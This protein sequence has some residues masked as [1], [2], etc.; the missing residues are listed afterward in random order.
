MKKKNVRP[1]ELADPKVYMVNEGD[2]DDDFDLS[3]LPKEG[4][5]NEA[6]DGAAADDTGKEGDQGGSGGGS[7]GDGA[8]ESG[9]GE[10]GSGKKPDGDSGDGEGGKAKEGDD[11]GSGDGGEGEGAAG[12]ESGD[13][14]GKE[15]DGS[16][17]GSGEGEGG[18]AEGKAGD[19]KGGEGE[20]GE[21]FFGDINAA[22]E[23]ETIEDFTPLA[24]DLGIEL[25]D[26]K[27]RTE[28]VEKVNNQVKEA[29][30][31]VDLSG[32]GEPTK[33]L[34]SH[35]ESGN[36]DLATFFNNPKITQFNHFLTQTP[37][38]K[39]AQVRASQ[40]SKDGLEHDEIEAKIDEELENMSTREL[41]DQVD[42]FDQNIITA[43]N[44]EI[45]T[46][47]GNEETRFSEAKTKAEA[48]V[49][50]EQ[51]QLVQYVEK[52][53]DFM[54][55]PLSEANRKGIVNAI[56]N[57]SFDLAV[58]KSPA[59]SKFNAFMLSRFG[60][61]FMEQITEASKKSGDEGYRRG[62]KKG[63]GTAFNQG[64]TKAGGAKGSG[65]PREK[66]ADLQDME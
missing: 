60:D 48:T 28:F 19:G 27:S 34:I 14:T 45:E 36:A 18:A 11:T 1:Y 10:E 40:L 63:K 21:D 52:Q 20:E 61:K 2:G 30:K 42:K 47:V 38:D 56:R 12:S 4:E 25:E 3:G 13:D 23:Q 54:G 33:K 46:I 41:K 39:F 9:G 37:E 66:Y 55:I 29:Q 53:E 64:S 8:G 44:S 31:K 6:G 5:G 26:P 32:Y 57:G 58:E 15:G 43:R 35:L 7:E 62:L 24:S 49:K 51:N 22:P 59:A 16:G 50:E 65:Q 17:K